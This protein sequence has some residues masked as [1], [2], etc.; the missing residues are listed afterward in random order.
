VEKKQKDVEAGR[1]EIV[2]LRGQLESASK[3]ATDVEAEVRSLRDAQSQLS[4][5]AQHG[6]QALKQL[7]EELGT[8]DAELTKLQSEIASL[9]ESSAS[10]RE[11]CD[12][13]AAEATALQ[14]AKGSVCSNM[15]FGVGC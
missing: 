14:A 11:R 10:F 7:Q 2:S 8:K 15:V 3:R 9:S 6:D 13:L 12:T 1:A 5:S 4:Q